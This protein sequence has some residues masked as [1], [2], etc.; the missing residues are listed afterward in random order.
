MRYILR[1]KNFYL[2][3]CVDAA[4]A[5]AA[6]LIA[7]LLRF[8]GKIPPSEWINIKN[9]LSFIIPVKLI[10]FFIF[11]LYRG[12]WRYTSLVDMQNV[13][14]AT[15]VSSAIIVL[16]ILFAHRFEGYP[17]SV[18][19][20][21]WVLTFLFIGGIRV[22]IR[23]VFARIEGHARGLTLGMS[24]VDV[25]KLLLIGAGNAGEKLL[26]EIMETPNLRYDV[27]G[28]VD[29]DPQKMKRS[30][31]GVPVLG[32]T[33]NL[34]KIVK[35]NKVDE[36]I[37]AIPSVKGDV[38]RRIVSLCKETGKRFRTVPGLWELI[39]GKVSVK[40][41]RDVTLA[42]LLGRE[43]V[44]LDEKIIREYLTNT[45]VMV[46]GAGGSIGS[47]LVRQICRFQPQALGILDFSEYNLFRVE[48]E[49]RQRFAS[50]STASYLVD[51]RDAA[52]V[53]KAFREFRPDVVFHAA[54]YKHVPIQEL[55]PWE[56]ICNN[57]LGT[58]N[59]I[60]A[61]LEHGVKRFV[62]V[63]TDKAV[64]P[65]NVMG[66]TKRVAEMLA[67]SANGRGGTLFMSVRFGNVLGS[68]GSAVPIFQEQIARGSP[69]TVTHPEIKRYF[70]S[71]PEAAQL[72]LQAGAMGRGGEIFI[73]D[74]GE[75][76]RI[77]DL[78][79]DL[80]RLS[81]LEPERDI[82][83]QF[84]GLR[85]GEKLYEE[86]ITVG[87]GIVPTGHEKILVLQGNSRERRQLEA[88]IEEL[89][90]CARTYNAGAI[91]EKLR[92][93]VPEYTPQQ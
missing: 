18:F 7:Y 8:D 87:E 46:T 43:E 14:K 47:E 58:R 10:I 88:Q 40:R 38:M 65:A 5:L 17:R 77:L 9:T 39:E 32:T 35:R 34:Q 59:L 67:E 73:L 36:I 26:R 83:I 86:L 30:I 68:S 61:S 76:I 20:I 37:I 24:D 72:I 11:D 74:M 75:P 33:A 69:V 53:E 70:M 55:N 85:P 28:F 15:S 92:H 2:L 78:A 81:G 57:V 62:L 21:D 50:I 82:P 1:N 84:T 51:I 56:A 31:H 63:S 25:K 80:I 49:C 41:I 44:R 89:L 64:R 45:R 13:F 71:I 54:A 48:M 4:L 27:V 29:D 90:A 19:I 93:I 22:V 60:D 3:F 79:R 23:L 91:K 6:Y 16:V 42:D 52:S 12:M 66:A